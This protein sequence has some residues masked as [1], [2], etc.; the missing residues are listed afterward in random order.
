MYI[1]KY[2]SVHFLKVLQALRSWDI[3]AYEL[4][5][6]VEEFSRSGRAFQAEGTA[7]ALGK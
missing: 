4:G 7:L 3:F 2:T 5:Y 6:D 1:L